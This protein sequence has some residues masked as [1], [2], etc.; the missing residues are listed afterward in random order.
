[1]SKVKQIKNYEGLYEINYKGEVRSI[2]RTVLGTDG[3]IYPFKGKKLALT[4]H[5]DTGYLIVNLWKNNKGSGFYVHRLVAQAF[6]PNNENKPEVNHIDGNKRNNHISNLEWVTSK[7]NTQHAINTGLKVYTNRLTEEEFLECL[8]V[9]LAGE[10][11]QKL[12]ERVPYKVPFLSTKIRQIARKHNL[13]HLLDV[14]LY[15][16]KVKR[17]RINGKGHRNN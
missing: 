1:M 13:E 7:E 15:E 12:S 10:S 8:Q 9:I 17:A 3:V 16:Q 2:D 6:I 11:Y 5:K 4:P 14:A